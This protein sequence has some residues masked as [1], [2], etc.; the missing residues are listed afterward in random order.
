MDYR[1]TYSPVRTWATTLL[2]LV[3][4]IINHQELKKLDFAHAF[5]QALDETELCIDLPKGYLVLGQR[6]DH[7][8]KLLQNVYWQ[9]QAGWVWN[10]FL[11]KGLKEMGFVQSHHDM[12]LLWRAS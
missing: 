10:D 12:C 6:H 4:S 11:I 1:D 3:I 9:K 5:P 8:I 7:A 2:V